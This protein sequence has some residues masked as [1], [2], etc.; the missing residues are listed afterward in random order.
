[1][2]NLA[3]YLKRAICVLCGVGLFPIF[4]T[5][6]DSQ[7]SVMDV[8][9][10]NELV[11]V[12]VNARK[13]K[14]LFELCERFY[15]EKD[16]E[17]REWYAAL[18]VRGTVCPKDYAKAVSILELDEEL[19]TMGISSAMMLV[20]LYSL[21]GHGISVDETKI[22]KYLAIEKPKAKTPFSIFATVN[23]NGKIFDSVHTGNYYSTIVS[24]HWGMVCGFVP[25][26]KKL[27]LELLNRAF[28]A[29]M[30]LD[31]QALRGVEKIFVESGDTT[32]FFAFLKRQMDSG[33]ID[34]LE[35]YLQRTLFGINRP[36]DESEVAEIITKFLKWPQEETWLAIW[37]AVM[38]KNG[39]GF[40]QDS[41]KA[42]KYFKIEMDNYRRSAK[43][44][45]E[46]E[47]S[48]MSGMPDKTKC[49]YLG[50]DRD[51]L[52]YLHDKEYAMEIA[53]LAEQSTETHYPECGNPELVLFYEA[54]EMNDKAKE[55]YAKY[56]ARDKNFISNYEKE[57]NNN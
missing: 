37:P 10:A 57:K 36:K 11:N 56:A 19:G 25:P 14:E 3:Y 6:D 20:N 34:T 41:K 54:A 2:K 28:E 29:E 47:Y 21:G 35:F 40:K 42:A 22:D 17:E 24:L 44:E 13:E 39:I 48:I 55:L 7:I 38:Y 18:Y 43:S 46:K 5:A 52:P 51:S 1:M 31:F 4:V 9:K 16:F 23:V 27:A 8:R 49:L 32:K 53:K 15:K 33:R 30:R 50:K 45:Y 26:N 12:Y